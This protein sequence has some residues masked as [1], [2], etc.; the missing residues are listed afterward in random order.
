MEMESV[1]RSAKVLNEQMKAGADSKELRKDLAN[2]ATE[3]GIVHDRMRTSPA[4]ERMLRQDYAAYQTALQAFTLIIDI[5][6]YHV[7]FERCSG[8]RHELASEADR[9]RMSRDEQVADW[10]AAAAFL[11]RTIKCVEQYSDREDL[12]H[13]RADQIGM[14]CPKFEF[15]TA[16]LANFAQ[17]KLSVAENRFINP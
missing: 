8:P 4:K 13:K 5:E 17:E 16:C 6:D 11:N 2:F 7:M 14:K 3:L 9:E 1:Y 10:M 15:D 12:L